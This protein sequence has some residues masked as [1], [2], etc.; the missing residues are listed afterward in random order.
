MVHPQ[1]HLIGN[2][3]P[4]IMSRSIVWWEFDI[5]SCL[6]QMS[7]QVWYLDSSIGFGNQN[8]DGLYPLSGLTVIMKF[9]LCFMSLSLNRRDTPWKFIQCHFPFKLFT[10]IKGCGTRLN[11]WTGLDISV[12]LIFF[13]F[14]AVFIFIFKSNSVVNKLTFSYY[15]LC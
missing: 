2:I 4:G 5:D 9:H 3:D 14:F 6:S 12:R 7:G 10:E 1:T 8:V 13:F 15:N 11:T